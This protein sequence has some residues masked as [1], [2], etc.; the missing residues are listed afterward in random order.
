MFVLHRAPRPPAER[1][2]RR[3]RKSKCYF[4]LGDK[5]IDARSRKNGPLLLWLCAAYNV[6]HIAADKSNIQGR[7]ESELENHFMRKFSIH[8]DEE[9]STP[10]CRSV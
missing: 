4:I 9:A 1:R 7:E 8:S 2:R 3:R 5:G 10:N 6:L